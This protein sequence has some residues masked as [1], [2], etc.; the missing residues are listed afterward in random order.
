MFWLRLSGWLFVLLLIA[1]AVVIGLGSRLPAERTTTLTAIVHASP[2]RIWPL[3]SDAAAQP[4]WR[5]D[6]TAA[7]QL[8]DTNNLPCWLEHHDRAATS[9]CIARNS[10]RSSLVL[11][12]SDP[13]QPFQVERRFL[14]VPDP[15][16]QATTRVTLIETVTIAP[17]MLRFYA[18]YI[19]G[20]QTRATRLLADLDR[21]VQSP[22][23]PNPAKP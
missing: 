10:P 17:A 20:E 11:R 9:V 6:L 2:D 13:R 23:S 3:L 8:P 12:T 5:S 19:V 18:H 14:L 21:A 4:Q 1:T 22:P 15:S 7:E 16:A